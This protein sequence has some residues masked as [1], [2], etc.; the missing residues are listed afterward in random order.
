MSRDE[1]RRV[2]VDWMRRRLT[3]YNMAAW[4]YKVEAEPLPSDCWC[5]TATNAKGLV[6]LCPLVKLDAD[7][8][9]GQKSPIYLLDASSE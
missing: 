2:V 3:A 8:F 4:L 1:Q 5:I 6:V 7:G 9:I